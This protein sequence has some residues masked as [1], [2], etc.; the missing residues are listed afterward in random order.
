LLSVATN[1]TPP[2]TVTGPRIEWLNSTFLT[3]IELPP[4]P[5]L[6]GV[7]DG[8]DLAA[9]LRGLNRRVPGDAFVRETS[10]CCVRLAP[11]LT[12]NHLVA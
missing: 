12:S 1:R 2:A 7:I 6:L 10:G 3:V 5:D 11:T 9:V 8:V 4:E